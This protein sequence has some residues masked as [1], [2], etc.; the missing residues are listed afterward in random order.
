MGGSRQRGAVIATAFALL[1]VTAPAPANSASPTITSVA[2]S[3]VG[4]NSATTVRVTGSG[5]TPDDRIFIRNCPASNPSAVYPVPFPS[6][7]SGQQAGKVVFVDSSTV[8]V[9]MPTVIPEGICDV[10]VGDAVAPDALTFVAAPERLTVEIVNSS[11]RP[12]SEVWVSAAYNCP[13][14]FSSPPWP[15]G[16]DG[17]DTDGRVNPH[18][19]WP[20]RGGSD[21]NRFWYE[22]YAGEEPLP[23][24]TGRRLSD[25]PRVPDR[26]HAYRL[27]VANID[28]GVVYVSYGAAVNTGPVKD[29]RAPS[30]LDSPT[31]FDVFELTFHGSGH[32]AGDAGSG[33]WTNRVYAN[34]TAVAGLGILMDMSGWDNSEGPR[35]PRPA[36]V[37]SGIRWSDGLGVHDVYR[38]LASAGADVKDP[39]VVVTTD[40]RP[41]GASNFLRFVSPSTNEGAGF[42]DLG[43]GPDSYLRWVADQRRPLTVVGL[44][45]GAGEGQGTWFCYQAERFHAD[46]PTTLRGSHGFAT[47]AAAAD[48][49]RRD[50][51]GGTAGP[52]ITTAT[53][54]TSGAAGPV[55]SRAVYMQDNS[56]LV[57]GGIA[58][59]NDLSNAVYRDFIVSFAYGFWGSIDGDAGWITTSWDA[60]QARAFRSA[61]PG[62]GDA[63][64]R[65]NSYAEAIWQVGNAYGMPYSDTFDN[66]GKGNPLV[67]GSSITTLRVTLRPDGSWES[68]AA[69]LPAKQGVKARKGVR[70]A[71]TPLTP[72]GLG[73]DVT[74]PGVT[75]SVS[76]RLP[77]SR[78]RAANGVWFIR[79]QGVIKGTPTRM[80]ARTTYVVTAR[81]DSGNEA[82]ARIRLRIGR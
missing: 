10:V 75:Y 58:A 30:Y 32:S 56:F 14:A 40:G 28:S 74:Y 29:G 68:G 82:T 50:C 12:D 41:P 20:A 13:L 8:L 18:Y 64:P 54:P 2:P 61:W 79:S 59:G 36:R 35:G 6:P 67:S 77:T 72:V 22:V 73:A 25:L 15:P 3:T 55:T 16:V 80:A 47:R 33:R 27:S 21:P 46:G 26:E 70:F 81:D 24:F 19:S 39:R 48:E 34:I 9:T 52:V 11:G 37:G 69:L 5:F 42:A 66:A 1:L 31:R 76:P 78:K 4:A 17:C 62:L 38:V 49:A 57:D 63:P 44:Y 45:T 23:A 65:W 43:A 51:A 60:G 71:T 53:S 7:G